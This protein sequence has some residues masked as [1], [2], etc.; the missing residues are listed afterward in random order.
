MCVLFIVI[1][2]ML[3]EILIFAD[4]NPIQSILRIHGSLALGRPH[5]TYVHHQ[6]GQASIATCASGVMYHLCAACLCA[7]AI[8]VAKNHHG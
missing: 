4:A 1:T 7:A 2:Y 6:S 5:H 8:P 3:L